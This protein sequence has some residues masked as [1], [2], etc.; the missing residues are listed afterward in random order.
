MIEFDTHNVSCL[1]PSI[2]RYSVFFGIEFNTHDVLCLVSF[3]FEY[4]LI[5]SIFY[6]LCQDIFQYLICFM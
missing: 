5:L 1:V 4:R 3:G 6:L 2:G